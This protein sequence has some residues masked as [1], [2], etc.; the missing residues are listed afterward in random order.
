MPE[1]LP[2]RRKTYLKFRKDSAIIGQK[3]V[4]VFGSFCSGDFLLNL[5]SVTSKVL[6]IEHGRV[7]YSLIGTHCFEFSNFS[8]FV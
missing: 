2:V 7:F 5:L 6:G 4:H 3:G 8:F 1:I